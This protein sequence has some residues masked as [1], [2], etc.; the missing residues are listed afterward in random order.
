MHLIESLPTSFSISFHKVFDTLEEEFAEKS[1]I[2]QGKWHWR[3]IVVLVG[4]C[5]SA[6]A[7]ILSLF[8]SSTMMTIL[9]L[10]VTAILCFAIYFVSRYEEQ[11]RMALLLGDFE[12]NNE[13]LQQQVDALQAANSRFETTTSALNAEVVSVRAERE[14]LQTTN[15]DLIASLTQA[16]QSAHDASETSR[17]L[18]QTL[19]TTEHREK[20]LQAKHDEYVQAHKEGAA[21]IAANISSLREL[22]NQCHEKQTKLS[23][24]AERLTEDAEKLGAVRTEV[25]QLE[26]IRMQLGK[27]VNEL[28]TQIDALK[29]GV[30]DGAQNSQ[31]LSELISRVEGILRVRET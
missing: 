22:D 28:R 18:K 4:I 20:A 25:Q 26:T 8:Q 5:S 9:L 23:R 19:A 12:E 31:V 24:L 14:H 11:K 3:S 21:R 1:P 30:A 29:L 10:A 7:L 16:R 6:F 2:E 13:H 15:A 27:H 17:H